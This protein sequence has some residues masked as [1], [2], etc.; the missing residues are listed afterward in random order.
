MLGVREVLVEGQADLAILCLPDGLKEHNMFVGAGLAVWPIGGRGS[1]A[2]DGGLGAALLRGAQR[3]WL[4]AAAQAAA[5]CEVQIDD[6]QHQA[7]NAAQQGREAS[8]EGLP[9]CLG[10]EDGHVELTHPAE[11]VGAV[12]G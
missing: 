6:H 1:G 5:R 7:H 12:H 3:G 10:V 9:S 11:V 2:E 8:A 4:L